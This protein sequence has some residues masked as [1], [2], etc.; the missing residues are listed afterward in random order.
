MLHKTRGIA[1]SYIRYKETSII[2]KIY[3]EAFGV[4]SYIINGVRNSK[5]KASR[6]AL[7]QPLTLLDLVVYHRHR[8]ESLH[9]LSEIRNDR[10]FRQLP[11]DMMKA[12]LALFVT[13]VLTR[14]LHEEEPNEPLFSFLEDAILYL[15]DAP[16]GFENFHIQFLL[17]FAA[18]LGFGLTGG[19]DLYRQLQ[20]AQY[21][22]LPD[23]EQRML[24]E[25]LLNTP[26]GVPVRMSRMLRAAILDQILFFYKLHIENFDGIKSLEV[27]R[28]VMK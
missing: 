22:H 28:E 3:T 14:T 2:A 9:R 1:L 17:R 15:E 21:M 16:S 13:E 6:M 4:Q 12:C 25:Q 11:F 24:L 5:A 18:F 19:Q 10:P 26:Y 7:F 20:E 23:A 27:L 8:Q